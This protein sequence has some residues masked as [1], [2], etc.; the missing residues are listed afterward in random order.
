MENVRSNLGEMLGWELRELRLRV[1]KTDKISKSSQMEIEK[2]REKPQA[3][4]KVTNIAQISPGEGLSEGLRGLMENSG[5]SRR[6]SARCSG[7]LRN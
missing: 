3:E 4:K 5:T 7:E 1:T 2:S 6:G